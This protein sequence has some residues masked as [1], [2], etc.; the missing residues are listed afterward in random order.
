VTLGTAE[1]YL[2]RCSDEL[3]G[4]R[5]SDY[6]AAQADHVHVVVFDSL[7]GRITPID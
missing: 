7:V 2:E 5:I 4:D 6:V 1:S 3:P